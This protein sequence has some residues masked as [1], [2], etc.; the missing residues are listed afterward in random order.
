MSYSNFTQNSCRTFN[1]LVCLR[2][3]T[4]QIRK[5]LHSALAGS[6][7][8]VPQVWI[9]PKAAGIGRRR[10]HAVR[11]ARSWVSDRWRNAYRLYRDIPRSPRANCGLS[12]NSAL[13]GQPRPPEKE[14]SSRAQTAGCC[15]QELMPFLGCYACVNVEIWMQRS[16]AQFNKP[17]AW[18][19]ETLQ[20]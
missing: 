9:W 11:K 5:P 1:F 6:A 20:T 10:I 16:S 13:P 7:R 8:S 14:T 12:T 4:A 2:I 19:R 18:V 3:I 17:N 15:D